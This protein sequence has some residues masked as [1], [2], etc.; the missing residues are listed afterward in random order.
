M[1]PRPEVP[2]KARQIRQAPQQASQPHRDHVRAAEGLA[3]GCNTL[4]PMP[5][6]LPL[7]HRPRR[8]R[9]VLAL[10]INESGA[11]HDLVDAFHSFASMKRSQGIFP[12]PPQCLK[13]IMA[14]L[15]WRSRWE[16]R[17]QA[18]GAIF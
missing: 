6:G 17:R 15:I 3:T 12:D 14:E 5:Q 11:S 9:L 10:K 16:A 2:H 13:I 18:E 1:H 8:N 7:G 4:R